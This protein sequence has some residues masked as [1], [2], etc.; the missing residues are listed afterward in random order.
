MRMKTLIAAA[1]AVIAFGFRGVRDLL[2]AGPQ[3]EA[4]PEEPRPF[5]RSTNMEKP[6]RANQWLGYELITD[7]IKRWRRTNSAT[8][9]DRP[10]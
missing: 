7:D 10:R 4:T 6:D 1:A 3:T 5:A 2:A 9:I 8:S